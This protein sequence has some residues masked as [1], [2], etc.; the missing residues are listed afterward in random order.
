MT[1]LRQMLRGLAVL[2]ALGTA[3]C[4]ANFENTKLAAGE[5]NPERR[6]IEPATP[7]M[8]VILMSFSGGG[9]RAAALASAVLREMADTTY[10]V[11][12]ARR[13]LTDDVKLISSVSRGS[14]TSAWFGLHHGP[15]RSD[16]DLAELRQKFLIQDNMA[17]LGLDAVNPITWFRVVFGNFS[18]IQALEELFDQRLFDG[19]RF[20]AFNQPGKPFIVLNTT[21]MAGGETFALVPRRFDDICSRHDMLPVSTGVAASAAFPIA[22]TPVAFKNYSGGCPGQLRNGERFGIDLSNPYTLYL[23]LPE[24]RD[25]R[26]TNDL[27]RGPSPFR[28]IDYLY[29]LDGGLADNLG[30]TSL[31]SAMINP[32]DSVG[33]LRAINDGKIKKLVVMVVNARSDPPNDIYADADRPGLIGQVKTVTSVPIDANTASSQITLEGLLKELAEAAASSDKAK[34]KGMAI[35]GVTIDFDQIPVD[36]E[37]HRRLR[38]AVK[39]VPTTW[40]LTEQQLQTTETAGSFLL[41]REP[42]FQ[43]VLKDL[44]AVTSAPSGDAIDPPIKCNTAIQVDA[45][46]TTSKLSAPR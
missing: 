26:Y 31:R 17:A 20:E 8:P 34:F 19:A 9:S 12:D 16:G 21:D 3:A 45:N 24:Y 28:N 27:R 10:D 37:D 22:L 23:N 6:S 40:T 32:Y 5:D 11:G 33:G 2:S 7:D 46:G 1:A 30:M 18:R 35:Y 4:G 44:R 13:S 15:G 29:F 42:C 43:A 14:V 36:T 25:A 39:S 38:D 41:H